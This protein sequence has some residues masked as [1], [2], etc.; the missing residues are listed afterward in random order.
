MRVFWT[1]VPREIRVAVEPHLKR[2]EPLLPK[3]VERLHVGFNRDSEDAIASVDVTP[4]YRSMGL[5]ICPR[6]LTLNED[7][8]AL[9]VLHECVH[10]PQSPLDQAFTNLL[11]S[12]V[13]ENDPLY[14]WA[15]EEWRKACEACTSDI[16]FGIARMLGIKVPEDWSGK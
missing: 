14:G 1:G 12:T 8:R 9:T 2:F 5:S 7:M 4:E 3:W 11:V 16:E 13:D 10:V 15:E 6:F